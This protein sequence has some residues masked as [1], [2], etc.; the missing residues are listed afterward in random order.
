MCLSASLSTP[1]PCRV[2]SFLRK[3][4]CAISV[5]TWHITQPSVPTSSTYNFAPTRMELRSCH[6]PEPFLWTCGSRTS[7]RTHRRSSSTV[8]FSCPT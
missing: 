1:T 2:G 7:R 4:V 8:W 6:F 5:Y 3:L